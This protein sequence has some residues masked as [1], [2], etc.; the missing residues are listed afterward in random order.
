MWALNDPS[1]DGYLKPLAHQRDFATSQAHTTY[2]AGGWGCGK[3]VADLLYADESIALNSGLTGIIMQP[4]HRMMREFVSTQFVPAFQDMIIKWDRTDNVFHMRDGTRVVCLSAHIPERIEMYNAAWAVLDEAGLMQ[5]R[6]FERIQARVRDKRAGCLRI[7]LTGTPHY[8]WLKD[9]FEGQDNDMRRIIHARTM[10]N[11]HLH[12]DY[13]ANLTAACPAR[14]AKAYLEGLFVPPGGAVYP[15]WDSDRHVIDYTYSP[16][17]GPTVPI[18]DWSPRT[19]HVL[20]VQLLSPG[21]IL[22]GSSRELTTLEASH[23]WAAMVIVGELIPDG[24]KQAVSVEHLADG[25]MSMGFDF[26]TY[27]RE[28]V[29]D[30]AGAAVEAGAGESAIAIFQRV[31]GLA[32]RYSTIPA[33]RSIANG[34]D[35]VRR[36][37]EPMDGIP[38]LYVASEVARRAKRLPKHLRARSV[39]NAIPGYSYDEP[40]DGKAVNQL[41]IKDGVTDHACDDTRYGSVAYFPSART[42]PGTMRRGI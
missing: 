26:S 34:V 17:V 7:G 13:V 22:P 32:A 25:V 8:G 27:P 36:L 1:G 2:L 21:M 30:P 23:K 12:P 42:M 15:E 24:S 33:E 19:P 10:D 14:L 40:K 35:C 6:I 16:H 11:P 41:P 18:V 20:A 29:C 39:V 38:R 4:T 28:F 31:T 5:R 9:E 37:L 3:S